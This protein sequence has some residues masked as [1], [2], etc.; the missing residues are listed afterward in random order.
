MERDFWLAFDLLRS[1]KD[2]A[3]FTVVRESVRDA[4]GRVADDVRVDREKSVLKQAAVQHLYGRLSA[5]LRPGCGDAD[6][7]VRLTA[8]AARVRACTMAVQHAHVARAGGARSQCVAVG[9]DG[10]GLQGIRTMPACLALPGFTHI[11]WRLGLM[12]AACQCAS[13]FYQQDVL[14][15]ACDGQAALHPTPAV[16]G[17]PRADAREL[18]ASAE[19][20]DRGLYAGP[21]GWIGGDGAEFA[22]A[23]RSALLQAP[24]E[25][26]H[27]ALPRQ[28]TAG[29]AV[30][31]QL[32]AYFSPWATTEDAPRHSCISLYAGV[33]IVRGSEAASEVRT[34]P[35]CLSQVC[36]CSNPS[37]CLAS[38]LAEASR[39]SLQ[40]ILSFIAMRPGSGRSSSLRS[41][42][43]SRCCTRR[44]R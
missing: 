40:N 41:A 42:S 36:T 25:A 3:E 2:H 15:L 5:R 27:P 34:A 14:S 33:G 22:V 7:L 35:S 37:L 12:L 10:A 1:A 29:M 16:C 9:C 23:I 21:F 44:P 13:R 38:A 31:Q 8:R 11:R 24:H 39:G 4:L 43:S 32:P 19:E 18:L 6:L 17:R 26:Q 30:G 20:F 28:T